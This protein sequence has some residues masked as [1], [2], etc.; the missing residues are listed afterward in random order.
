MPSYDFQLDGQIDMCGADYFN[1]KIQSFSFIFD[2][3]NK[4]DSTF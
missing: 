4:T 2:P 1:D 3:H